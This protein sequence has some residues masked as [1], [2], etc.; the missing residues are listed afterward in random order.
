MAKL[1]RRSSRH[2][3]SIGG[4]SFSRSKSKK[5]VHVITSTWN[6]FKLPRTGYGASK[7]EEVNSMGK[8]TTQETGWLAWQEQQK[9][10]ARSIT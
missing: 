10:L 5:F 2:R 1:P 4:R 3:L 8:C 7:R 9:K 6:D